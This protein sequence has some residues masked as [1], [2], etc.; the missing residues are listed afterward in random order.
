MMIMKRDLVDDYCTWLFDI[1]FELKNRI[2]M[3][4][5]DT[6]QGRFYGRISEIIFN[7]WLDEKLKSGII[8]KEEIK[9]IPCVHMEKVNWFKKGTAF[10]KA[11]FLGKKYEGSF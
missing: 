11:K 2:E 7:V 5:L 3:P 10:L 1:L 9:E 4:E 6:F 8:K